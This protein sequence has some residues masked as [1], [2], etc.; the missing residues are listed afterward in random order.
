MTSATTAQL[1]PLL[2]QLEP[3]Y[4]NA[5]PK[6]GAMRDA[7]LVDI[8][9]G[10]TYMAIERMIAQIAKQ[11]VDGL[12]AQAQAVAAEMVDGSNQQTTE[13]IQKSINTAYGIDITQ[14]LR[15][16]N[17][18]PTLTITRAINVNLIKTIPSQYF[19]KLNQVVFQGVQQGVRSEDLIDQIKGIYNVTDNRARTIARDQTSKTNAAINRARQQDLGIDK[20]RWITSNDERVRETHAANADQIFSWDDPPAETGN[21]GDDINCFPGETRVVWATGVS[22]VYRRHYDGPLVEIITDSGALLQATP[23]HPISTIHGMLP[24]NEIDPGT[25]VLQIVDEPLGTMIGTEQ[26]ESDDEQE[27][28]RAPGNSGVLPMPES[29]SLHTVFQSVQ[30][31]GRV[32]AYLVTP[33]S[34]HGDGADTVAQVAIP[35]IRMAFGRTPDGQTRSIRAA[36]VIAVR[37]FMYNGLVFNLETTSGKYAAS[38]IVV[39]NC[40]CVAA[41]II[42]DYDEGDGSD[43][44]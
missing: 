5:R 19:E 20:Y 4:T 23:N 30:D 43:D 35:D 22:K 13:Q 39:G 11:T 8:T 26:D 29:V 28:Q 15:A 16:Q 12:D 38:G 1:F 17:I 40:R 32:T 14:I 6:D 21:P 27:W 9:S 41:P 44:S 34:F 18:Q 31:H 3:S 2:Q 24:A 37:T 36:Q 42:G 10:A 7:Q 33:A 25:F